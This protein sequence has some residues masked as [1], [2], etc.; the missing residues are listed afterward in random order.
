MTKME[1]CQDHHLETFQLSALKTC[2]GGAH[3]GKTHR[4]LFPMRLYCYFAKTTTPRI[5]GSY[6]V[7]GQVLSFK[8][9]NS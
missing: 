1:F 3:V 8:N 2:V 6:L 9:Y 4:P 5:P 7:L